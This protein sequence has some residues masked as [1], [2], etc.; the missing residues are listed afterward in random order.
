MAGWY[1]VSQASDGQYRFVLKA[2]NGEVILTSE[3]YKTKASAQ[4]GIESVQKNSPEDGRYE[5]L[6]AKNGKPYFNL[7]AANYQVIGTSQFYSSEQSREKGIESV[8]NNGS[9]TTIKDLI[10]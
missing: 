6:E 10:A 7:K 1:E 9:S 5:R 4:N 3:L 8:K 2:G